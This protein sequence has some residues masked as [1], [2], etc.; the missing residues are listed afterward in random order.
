[1][2]FWWAV[3]RSYFD[4]IGLTRP[5]EVPPVYASNVIRLPPRRAGFS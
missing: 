4:M 2:I 5:A 3:W 1:M